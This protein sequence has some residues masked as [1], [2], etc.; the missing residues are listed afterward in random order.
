MRLKCFFITALLGSAAIATFGCSSD[1]ANSRADSVSDCKSLCAL[2]P[3]A[4]ASETQCA[5]S[6]AESMG[7]PVTSTPACLGINSPQTCEAC[8]LAV[9]AGAGNCVTIAKACAE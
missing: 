2:Q 3:T 1:D 8:Y 4:T 5:T 6:S 9:G 7:F